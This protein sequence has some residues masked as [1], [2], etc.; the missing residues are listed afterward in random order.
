MIGHFA[1][2][3]IDGIETY[4]K[5][6][7]N[8]FIYSHGLFVNANAINSFHETLEFS[9]SESYTFS[10]SASISQTLSNGISQQVGLKDY[11]KIGNDVKITQTNEQVQGY[12]YGFT[13]EVKDSY[14]YD[15]NIYAVPE[16]YELAMAVVCNANVISFSYI[17]YDHFWWGDFESRNVDD[18]N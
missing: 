11:V 8:G 12:S 9:Y 18:R 14:T 3:T 10:Y 13:K 1:R 17:I 5:E 16:N 2:V 4:S 6:E 15:Y 7:G